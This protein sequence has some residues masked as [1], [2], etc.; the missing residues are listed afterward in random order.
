MSLVSTFQTF[1]SQASKKHSHAPGTKRPS[2]ERKPLAFQRNCILEQTK[3]WPLKR[4]GVMRGWERVTAHRGGRFGAIYPAEELLL[5]LAPRLSW[6]S[7]SLGSLAVHFVAWEPFS[8]AVSAA[9]RL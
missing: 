9:Q 5:L 6:L 8:I 7:C 2:S 1:P 3:D 4:L